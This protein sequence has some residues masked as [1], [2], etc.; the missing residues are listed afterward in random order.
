MKRDHLTFTASLL[1]LVLAAF[2]LPIRSFADDKKDAPKDVDFACSHHG[3]MNMMLTLT[4]E[5]G[6]PRQ[7]QIE[8]GGDFKHWLVKIGDGKVAPADNGTKIKVHS[9]DTITW[10]LTDLN[11][12]VV[13]A[14]QKVAE[15]MFKELKAG[16]S[17]KL[18]D[19]NPTLNSP[20]WM[21]FGKTLWGTKR[22]DAVEGKTIIMVTGTVK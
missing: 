8:G 12:G 14:E 17:L 9:G 6:D 3:P 16:D 13:F 20:E 1:F 15:A 22:M 5:K 21:K 2:A 19:L 7:I 18:E 11:H 4:F 10:I